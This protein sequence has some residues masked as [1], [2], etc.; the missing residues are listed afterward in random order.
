MPRGQFIV[1]DGPDG[2]GKGTQIELLKGVL[3]QRYGRP[4]TDFVF[5]REPGGSPRA[6]LIRDLILSGEMAEASGLTML[7][8]FAAARADHVETVI[9]PALAAGKVVISDRF[10]GS[11]FAYQIIA[12]GATQL[13]SEFHGMHAQL[14]A[15]LGDW[16]TILLDVPPE[17]SHERITNRGGAKATHFDERSALFYDLVRSGFFKYENDFAQGMHSMNA[18]HTPCVVHHCVIDIFDRVIGPPVVTG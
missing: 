11:T 6:E 17:V 14:R 2:A 15:L 12:Q 9:K 5:T 10:D 3:P 18:D 13:I 4:A 16:T 8:L 7:H 1:I